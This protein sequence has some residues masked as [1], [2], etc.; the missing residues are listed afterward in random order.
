PA[1]PGR[2]AEP[3]APGTAD[4]GTSDTAT[5]DARA[6]R[7]RLLAAGDLPGFNDTYRWGQGAT[8]SREPRTPLGTC[9]RFDLT[10]IGATQVAVRGYR[11]VAAGTPDHAGELVADF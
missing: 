8:R 11:P 7:S 4:A 9:Q 3:P 2:S 5:S 6:L 1:P 10:S